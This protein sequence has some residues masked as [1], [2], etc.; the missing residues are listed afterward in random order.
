MTR[1]PNS[2]K[3]VSDAPVEDWTQWELWLQI[4]R[5]YEAT[6]GMTAWAA[7]DMA[8]KFDR[9]DALVFLRRSEDVIQPTTEG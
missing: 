9:A 1:I 8:I 7:A 5:V 4:S 2:V 6:N 3:R